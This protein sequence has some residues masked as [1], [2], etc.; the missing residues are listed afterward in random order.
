MVVMTLLA[1][2]LTMIQ[3]AHSETL[4][5]VASWYGPG[6][7]GKKTASGEVFDQNQLTIASQEI[8]LGSKVK[9]TNLRNK[10]VCHAKV[11]DRGPHVAGRRFDVSR[12]VARR[13]GFEKHGLE[14]VKVE[15][16]REGAK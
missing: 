10:K 3:P 12:Q 2:V 13:L 7:H 5:G 11:T 6:F 8:P 15:I 16:I 4:T 9:I 14:K 1:L